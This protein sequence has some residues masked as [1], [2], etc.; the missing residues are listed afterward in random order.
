[1]SPNPMQFLLLGG[2]FLVNN[3]LKINW[4]LHC[5]RMATLMSR[6]NDLV[7]QRLQQSIVNRMIS[8]LAVGLAEVPDVA[9]WTLLLWPAPELV[10]IRG[11]Y[12]QYPPAAGL[13]C[14]LVF[15]RLPVSSSGPTPPHSDLGPCRR[16]CPRKRAGV[17]NGREGGTVADRKPVG[18]C[19]AAGICVG[20]GWAGAP[21]PSPC[22]ASAWWSCCRRS[23]VASRWQ[24]RRSSSS[25]ARW[26]GRKST[27]YSLVSIVF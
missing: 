18:G 9:C 25:S 4:P 16:R 27:R 14:P 2:Q 12:Q 19:S 5:L 7:P 10:G 21:T 1:M 22:P 8:Y 11:R 17:P 3:W 20:C 26:P 23:R 6:T 24:P 13:C 15:P